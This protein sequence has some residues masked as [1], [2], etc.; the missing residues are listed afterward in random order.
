MN[1]TEAVDTTPT[2]NLEGGEHAEDDGEWVH[3]ENT[4]AYWIQTPTGTDKVWLKKTLYEQALTFFPNNSF[5]VEMGSMMMR[6][7][8]TNAVPRS[9]SGRLLWKTATGMTKSQ[10]AAFLLQEILDRSK[11][12][13]DASAS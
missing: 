10:V 7:A 1:V 8:H 6:F 2:S 3:L 12:T 5:P 11:V 13:A 9:A 4:K